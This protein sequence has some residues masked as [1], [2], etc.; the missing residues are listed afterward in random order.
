MEQVPDV[1]I[2]GGRA[3]RSPRR[4]EETARTPRRRA[5]RSPARD[6]VPRRVEVE[7]VPFAD[8]RHAAA[9]AEV[10]RVAAAGRGTGSRCRSTTSFDRRR[11]LEDVVLARVFPEAAVRGD[12]QAGPDDLGAS[13]R[14]DPHQLQDPVPILGGPRGGRSPPRGPVHVLEGLMVVL[15]E[16]HDHEVGVEAPDDQAHRERPVEV[17]RPSEA[18]RDASLA[19]DAD[20]PRE[21]H[22]LGEAEARRERVPTIG[23]VGGRRR[24]ADRVLLGR[25]AGVVALPVAAAGTLL[26]IP[27]RGGCPPAAG[28]TRPLVP[29]RPPRR[30]LDTSRPARRRR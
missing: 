11:E 24:C 1:P 23:G 4:S 13:G 27:R 20:E 19:G 30:A 29:R 14:G 21:E 8:Q 28:R 10:G 18:G 25:R 12:R 5:P 9:L 3:R 22:A 15:T 2:P 16:Q 6:R 26:R 17:V 7:P